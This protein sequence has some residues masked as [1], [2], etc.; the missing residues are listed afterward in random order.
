MLSFGRLRDANVI[1][2]AQWD[3]LNLITPLFRATELAGEAGE[4]CNVIKKLE[5]AKVGLRGSTSTVEQ[6]AE[7]LADI[8]ICADLLAMEFNIDLALAVKEKFNESS[9]KNDLEERL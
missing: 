2:D 1:R 5:R 3:P 4:A 7:E 8:V 9:I 6:L